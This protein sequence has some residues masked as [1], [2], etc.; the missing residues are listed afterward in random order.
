MNTLPLQLA[1][2]ILSNSKRILNKFI[3]AIDGF[4]TNDVFY[5][6]TD[7]LYI[8]SKHW[9]KLDKAGLVGKNVLQGKNDYKDGGI[10]Y[11]PF[12]APKIKYCLI[13]N[14]YGIIDKKSVS[15]DS[16][17]FLTI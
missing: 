2:F 10:W 17:M 13:F 3:H 16:Q 1:V 12:L 15:K 5:T 11:A 7:S 14:K 6:D 8:E 9:D 4:H